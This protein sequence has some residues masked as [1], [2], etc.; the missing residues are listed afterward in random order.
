MGHSRLPDPFLLHDRWG[1]VR[2]QEGKELAKGQSPW[3]PQVSSIHKYSLSS[4]GTV[5]SY[6]FIHPWVRHLELKGACGAQVLP[7]LS[8]W[9]Y[10]EAGSGNTGKLQRCGR[11]P[12]QGDSGGA[13]LE[14]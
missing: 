7:V 13:G 14:S 10:A 5:V 12:A 1:K 8:A 4:R 9:R 11:W 6:D 2:P 3:A